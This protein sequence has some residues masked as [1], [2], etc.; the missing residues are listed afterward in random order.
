M[1]ILSVERRRKHLVL[2]KTEQSDY[3]IDVETAEQYCLKADMTINDEQLDFIVKESNLIRAKNKALW[4]LQTRD[5]SAKEMSEK[6][7]R[8]YDRQTIDE[9]IAM[10]CESGLIDDK[11]FADM[12]VTELSEIRGMSRANIKR[13]L[14]KKGIAREIIDEATNMLAED[15]VPLIIAVI[16]QKYYNCFDDEKQKRRMIAGLARKGYS[17]NDIKRAIEEYSENERNFD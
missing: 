3:L 10:L 9:V 6:L 8:D 15:E 7:R 5:H 4:L 1:K 2:V 16:K 11:R 14:A 13:E 17:F 12:Y